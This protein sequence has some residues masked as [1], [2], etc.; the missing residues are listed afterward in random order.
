MKN[1][2]HEKIAFVI[3]AILLVAL[4]TTSATFSWIDDVKQVQFDND[5]VTNGAPLKSGVDIN[6]GIVIKD[7]NNT[8]NL[9]NILK[10][11]D[12]VYEYTEDGKAKKH[13][14]YDGGSHQ[15]DWSVINKNKGYFYESGDMHLS[16][17][18]S[19]GETFYFPRQGTD[20]YREGNK[21]D[22]N[23]NYISFTTKVSSPDA[24]VDFWFESLPTVKVHDTN[25]VIS[26]ARFSITADGKSH[27]Y[28]ASG[29][30]NTVSGNSLVA[31]SG[32][33]KTSTYTYGNND[34]T[35]TARG[36]NSNTLF[37]VK[38][39]DT[40][41]LNIKIWLEGGTDATITASDINM[42]LVS[43][44]AYTRKITVLD[45]TTSADASSWIN[46]N[47][48]TL[49]LTCPSVLNENA[50]EIYNTDN[51]NVANWKQIPGT[52][53][54]EHAPFYKLT[55][56]SGTDDSY[57]VDV[58][59][60]YCNEEMILYRCGASTN[61]N[62]NFSG[63]NTGTHTGNSGDYGVTYWNWWKS[64]LPNSYR[65]EMYTLYGSSYDDVAKERFGGTDTYK[66]Y[67]TWGSVEEIKVYSHNGSIDYALKTDGARL[68]LRD[69]S[70]EDT[71]GEI[72]TFVMYRTDNNNGTP[73]KAYIPTS[74]SKLQFHYYLNDN[75]KGTWGYRSWSDE[76][77]QRRP[78]KSTG[79]YSENSTTYHFDQNYGDDKG[80]GYWDG[81]E[82]VYLIKSSFLS[83]T[84][85]T[86]HA[87]MFVDG[88][89]TNKSAY[90]GEAL[91]RLKDT[92]NNDVSYT[93]NGGN[94]T[95]EVW[96]TGSPCVYNKIIFNNGDSNGGGDDQ[97]GVKKT[98]NLNLF[99]GCFY[100]VDGSKW[101][102]SLDDKGR[103]ASTS[104]DSGD[105]SGGGD[106][107]QTDSMDGYTVSS[108][109][110]FKVQIN[111]VEK[112]YD[113]KTNVA[114]G[115]TFKVDIELAE[116][117]S[118]I[119]VLGGSNSSDNY[120]N[121]GD[122]GQKYSVGSDFN[123]LNLSTANTNNFAFR[124]STAG[125]YIVTFAYGNSQDSISISSVLK[126]A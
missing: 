50:K 115:T 32:T 78:L 67:G 75:T 30:A 64:T 47:N 35:T 112:S 72:Y 85:I 121:G 103:D 84:S 56:D 13:T 27:V 123:G 2:K 23:V 113:A 19:D 94:Y 61:A 58:P 65:N 80:W 8:V 51:P 33:R 120:G 105:D 63:W 79:L 29:S 38:K 88:T 55:K 96:Q 53:G 62:D 93:W 44:W 12:L 25:N 28:S 92:S 108:N 86:A 43:S 98:G 37:S 125:H 48:A 3:V 89:N 83:S 109:F 5:N 70:D 100:Q 107:S 41:N 77:P 57:S 117:L 74:S 90:P 106:D 102:G 45:R 91:T 124:A 7:D 16:P 22:E 119:T 36:A 68:Y 95:A 10:E 122:P 99:P 116:G 26:T 15:P 73:W 110:K 114:N 24:T 1:K 81:A 54:Y 4:T 34:N 42:V 6:A 104:G 49:F 101:Y 111:N 71:S 76:N 46:N 87:Y 11:S 20:G 17:C 82:T 21:D 40:V 118:W 126:K 69:Y 9:G 66:G 39:G 59:L 31:V 18:Y 52:Q 60:V 97:I 14:K